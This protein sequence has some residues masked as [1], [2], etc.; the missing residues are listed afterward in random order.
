MAEKMDKEEKNKNKKEYTVCL[1]GKTAIC[2]EYLNGKKTGKGKIYYVGY[3]GFTME[4]DEL[5]G[6]KLIY[7][8]GILNGK[9]MEKEKNIMKMMEN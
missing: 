9:K 2:E 7:E 5:K 8:G 4:I 1:M 6:G 3:G